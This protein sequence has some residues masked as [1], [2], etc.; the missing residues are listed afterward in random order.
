M[1][2]QSRGGWE[3]GRLCLG[4]EWGVGRAGTWTG[5]H[6][7][8]L[9]LGLAGLLMS[10]LFCNHLVSASAVLGELNSPAI[11]FALVR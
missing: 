3:R 9:E 11:E 1:G 10:G 8:N 2:E 6:S 7:D 5:C 4:S